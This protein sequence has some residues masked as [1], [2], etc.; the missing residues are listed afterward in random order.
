MLMIS[1]AFSRRTQVQITPTSF[2][3]I[4][5]ISIDESQKSNVSFFWKGRPAGRVLY[6]D[7]ILSNKLCIASS[8]HASIPALHPG[9]SGP[10]F[11]AYPYAIP[12]LLTGRY[13]STFVH[14][15]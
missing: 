7:F 12:A 8:C 11:L 10:E 5:K 6:F 13:A 15:A 2:G 14:A 4:F 9:D 3:N 1:S